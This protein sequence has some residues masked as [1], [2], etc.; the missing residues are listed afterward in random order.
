MGNALEHVS[1]QKYIFALYH[2]C[3]TYLFRRELKAAYMELILV[4]H[5][6]AWYG[7]LTSTYQIKSE[8][9]WGCGGGG[10]GGQCAWRLERGAAF[11]H[12]RGQAGALSYT[13]GMQD[14]T[15]LAAFMVTVLGLL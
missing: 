12:G 8:C 15:E 14:A 5:D 1:Y 13:P 2:K 4:W 7:E 6:I 9:A 11:R 3:I 10:R